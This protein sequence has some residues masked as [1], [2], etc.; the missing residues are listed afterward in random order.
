MKQTCPRTCGFCKDNKK[1]EDNKKNEMDDEK[2][3]DERKGKS[4]P[5]Y[6]HYAGNR[7]FIYVSY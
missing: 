4:S 3:N 7:D 1:E 2:K 5:I 6:S